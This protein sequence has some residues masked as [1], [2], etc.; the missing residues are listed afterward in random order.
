MKVNRLLMIGF[1]ITMLLNVACNR[2]LPCTKIKADKTH[3][4]AS[5]E[6]YAPK[7]DL[8]YE[9]ALLIAKENLVQN[10]A[11]DISS[12]TGVAPKLLSDSLSKGIKLS[13]LE[14][15]CK[16]KKKYKGSYRCSVAIEIESRKLI[17]FYH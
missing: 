12:K 3:Y 15:I 1:A 9:K 5:G 13:Q 10:I 4:R 2:K 8:A 6:A 11:K 17:H 16:H 14:V 7:E